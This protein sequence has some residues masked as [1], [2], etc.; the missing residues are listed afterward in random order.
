MG[1]LLDRLPELELHVDIGHANLQ[2]PVNTTEEILAAYGARR[3]HAHLHDSKGAHADLHL[4]LGAGNISL[5]RVI[6]GLKRC[7]YDGTIT[8]DVLTPD[9]HHLE[10]S[11]DALR[12][13]WDEMPA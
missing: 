9:H 5:G 7:G 4:P 13:L 1:E 10:Y 2:V 12:R 6:R 3:R 11:R 8:L